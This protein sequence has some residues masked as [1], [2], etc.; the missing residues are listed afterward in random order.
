MSIFVIG[1]VLMSAVEILCYMWSTI[2]II[3]GRHVALRVFPPLLLTISLFIIPPALAFLYTY[4]FGDRLQPDEA[5]GPMGPEP[6]LILLL[7]SFGVLLLLVY[8]VA[9]AFRRHTFGINSA[10]R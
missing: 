3:D 5:P 10:L 2:I 1:L 9:A 4:L 7:W 6:V 8:N